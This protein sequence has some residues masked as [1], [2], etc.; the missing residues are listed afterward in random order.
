MGN[1]GAL[2]VVSFHETKSPTC[3]EGGA[4]LSKNTEFSK[5]LQTLM[6]EVPDKAH[7]LMGE[8]TTHGR[9][10]SIHMHQRWVFV[11]ALG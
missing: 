3:G 2:S 9:I 10:T 5:K 11:R 1:I 6:D 4:V 7:Y 8:V